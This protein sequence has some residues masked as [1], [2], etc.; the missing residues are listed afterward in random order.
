[1]DIIDNPELWSHYGIAKEISIITGR[2]LKSIE[3]VNEGYLKYVSSDILP[4]HAKQEKNCLRCS[5]IKIE[6]VTLETSPD[7]II[8]RLIN[9]GI[10]SVNLAVDLANYV[11]LDIGQPVNIFM[12]PSGYVIAEASVFNGDFMDVSMTS[13]AVCRYVRLIQEYMPEARAASALYDR[14]INSSRAINVQPQ[15]KY[16]TL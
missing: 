16:I 10:E 7:F 4:L 12:Y 11:L 3:Y 6:N 13:I 15:Y 14:G 1:M 8:N 2:E 5:A 9:C